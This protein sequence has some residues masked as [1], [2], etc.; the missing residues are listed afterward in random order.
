MSWRTLIFAVVGAAA[1][2]SKS[3]PP[4]PT[5]PASSEAISPRPDPAEQERKKQEKRDAIAKAQ[6]AFLDSAKSSPDDR[7]DA[8]KKLLDAMSW[9]SDAVDNKAALEKFRSETAKKII[10]RLTEI[11]EAETKDEQSAPDVPEKPE[12]NPPKYVPLFEKD[13]LFDEADDRKAYQQE[14]RTYQEDYKTKLTEYQK[15]VAEN[16]VATADM[17]KRKVARD[18]ERK[19]L[20]GQLDKILLALVSSKGESAGPDVKSEPVNVGATGKPPA[21]A[22][23]AGPAPT[24]PKKKDRASCLRGCI[25]SCSNDA[26]CERSC[27]SQKCN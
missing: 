14:L 26:N 7:V 2:C 22:P 19:Q 23:L 12:Y 1:A 4:D 16:R 20:A 10:D 15:A 27:V 17:K 21:T 24:P 3:T 11:D 18:S 8:Y 25:E 5:G 6:A 13:E 9:A